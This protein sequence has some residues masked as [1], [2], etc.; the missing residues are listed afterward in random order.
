MYSHVADVTCTF[1]PI[2][3]KGETYRFSPVILPSSWLKLFCWSDISDLVCVLLLHIFTKCPT[4]HRCYLCCSKPD[5]ACYCLAYRYTYYTSDHCLCYQ[6][7]F[8]PVF[9][10]SFWSCNPLIPSLL[11]LC[12]LLKNSEKPL[13]EIWTVSFFCH[14]R[15]TYR[16]FCF[17][18]V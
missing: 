11:S 7:T 17:D 1:P 5:R 16:F 9:W 13:L 14:F 12:Y 10:V 6:W 3:Q 2:R 18:G 4:S 8:H 15:K